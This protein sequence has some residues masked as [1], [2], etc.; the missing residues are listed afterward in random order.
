MHCT[1]AALEFI[2]HR[3]EMGGERL[4]SKALVALLGHITFS[5]AGGEGK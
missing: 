3:G 5:K 4:Q 1:P 2:K